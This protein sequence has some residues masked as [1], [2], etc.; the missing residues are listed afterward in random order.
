MALGELYLRRDQPEKAIAPFE[1]A[2]ALNP[3][4]SAPLLLLSGAFERAHQS[5]K[6]QQVYAEWLKI[7]PDNPIALNNLAFLL[8]ETGGDLDKALQ[9]ARHAL[10]KSPKDANISDTIGWIY[11]KKQMYSSASTV[12]RQISQRYPRNAGF[13]FHNAL[14]YLGS[15]DRLKAKTEL[16]AALSVK[17]PREIED[18]IKETLGQLQANR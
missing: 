5:A 3:T 4:S 14:A 8:C 10:D 6:A 12:F 16:Q 1:R 7:E 17:P 2:Q 13:R 9:L 15:G 18:K 11:M